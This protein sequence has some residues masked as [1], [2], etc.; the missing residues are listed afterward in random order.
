MTDQPTKY[1][2]AERSRS[3][4]DS[5]RRFS[6]RLLDRAPRQA[7]LTRIY[8]RVVSPIAQ[9][10][11]LQTVT[12]EADDPIAETQPSRW[13]GRTSFVA[14]VV[15][16]AMLVVVYFAFIAA[17]QYVAEMRLVVR[18]GIQES[19]SQGLQSLLAGAGGGG[20]A[21]PQA[22]GAT[23]DGG[24]TSVSGVASGTSLENAHIL[25]SYIGS[26]GLVDDLL[27]TV[28]L[29]EIYT[30]PEADFYARLKQDATR[31]E[32]HEYWQKVVSAF[33]DGNSGIVTVEVRA[34]RPEDALTIMRGIETL[35]EKLLN[36]ISDR[37]RQD[38]MRRATDEFA[39][40]RDEML[41][42]ISELER[43]RNTEGFIDP[44]QTATDTTKLLAKVTG[45][46]L[47]AE[48]QLAVARSS[49]ASDAPAIKVL[50]PQVE[51]LR[52][53]VGDLRAQI[54]GKG[55]DIHNIA[56]AL[57]RYEEV[58]IKQKMAE[59]L[60]TLASKGLEKARSAAE[61][62]SVYLAVFVPPALPDEYTYPKR[63]Q[64]SL[65]LSA[66]FAILWGIAALI[67]ASV[68]DHR[69]Q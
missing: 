54:A 42:A 34:F 24:G 61:A 25:T 58:S 31:D 12:I 59:T 69:L 44:V 40:S 66:A 60:Y 10:R 11:A 32:L 37:A 2:T 8:Q 63:W 55:G 21:N 65:L 35:S 50:T 13:F 5:L 68:D 18:A 4:V 33:V 9:P 29:R 17:N 28:D 64:F 41:A 1:E 46:L 14:C 39:R 51:T 53:Q 6:S 30:R 49:M 23:M 56:A 52:R 48:A 19:G 36:E 20:G 62:Q 22:G 45:D 7:E 57:A 16:P 43:Y 26:R 47:K 67:A 38:T 3:G 15:I 27:K